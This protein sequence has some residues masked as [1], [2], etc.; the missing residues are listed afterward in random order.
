MSRHSPQVV[1]FIDLE[2]CGEFFL[3][4]YVCRML[5]KEHILIQTDGLDNNVIKLKPPITFSL[6]DAD[7]LLQAMNRTFIEFN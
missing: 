5:L 6:E 3:C 4:V 7:K 1:K 2:M